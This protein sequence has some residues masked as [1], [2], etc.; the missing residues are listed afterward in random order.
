[1]ARPARRILA[2]V[3]VVLG[4]MAC[5]GLLG[6]ATL[7]MEVANAGGVTVG[8]KVVLN[9]VQIGAVQEVTA[10]GSGARVDLGIDHEHLP[11]LDPKTL[12][13]VREGDTS[14][15]SRVVA[16]S[17]L[18]VSGAPRGLAADQ[19]VRGYGGRTPSV[20]LHA[21]SDHPDCAKKIIEQLAVDLGTL[22]QGLEA[23]AP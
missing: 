10:T 23:P 7:H 5:G 3:A 2:G 9:G 18:C 22:L 12:F 17:N 4:G 13:V 6:P 15:P 11:L 8:D 16:A 21:G 19:T 14:P 20:I 1:M